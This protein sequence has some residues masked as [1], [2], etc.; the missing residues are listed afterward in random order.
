MSLFLIGD[1]ALNCNYS[2]KKSIIHFFF[3]IDSECFIFENFNLI[4]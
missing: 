3:I 2:M 4:I 1:F